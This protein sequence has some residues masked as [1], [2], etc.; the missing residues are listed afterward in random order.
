MHINENISM[1][2]LIIWL[3]AASLVLLLL[4]GCASESGAPTSGAT[5]GGSGGLFEEK[6]IP[7]PKPAPGQPAAEEQPSPYG[8][9]SDSNQVVG[10][11]VDGLQLTN[12]RWGDHDAYFRVVFE[13]GTAE[14]EPVLQ[15]PHAETSLSQDGKTIKVILGGI[16][17]IGN[18]PNVTS[19]ELI[20]GDSLV[21]SIKR[22]PSMDDQAMIYE[23]VMSRPATYALAG[24]GSPGRVV[25]D[26]TK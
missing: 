17:S 24:L 12:I 20:V 21:T 18:S 22:I 11:L 1:N 3:A 19:G 14:G 6:P 9:E 16:R 25:I 7:A 8:P 4:A 2:R 26:I 23:I 10:V 5:N 13:M 15:V